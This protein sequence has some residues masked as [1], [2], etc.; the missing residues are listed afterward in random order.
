MAQSIRQSSFDAKPSKF[1]LR[2]SRKESLCVANVQILFAIDVKPLAWQPLATGIA[3]FIKDYDR[4][5]YFIE[6]RIILKRVN[7]LET[8]MTNVIYSDDL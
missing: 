2:R 6:V 5:G 3:R 1:S 4:R 7:I 8:I